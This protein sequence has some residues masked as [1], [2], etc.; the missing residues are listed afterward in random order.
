MK[1]NIPIINAEDLMSEEEEREVIDSLEKRGEGNEW[2]Y[3]FFNCR[4][5]FFTISNMVNN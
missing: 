4:S 3:S 2:I 1:K 5:L